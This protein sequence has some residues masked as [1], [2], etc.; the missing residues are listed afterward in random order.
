MTSSLVLENISKGY[1]PRVPLFSNV[2]LSLK[3]GECASVI[4]P[5]A[6]GKSTLLR[7]IAGV[8]APTTGTIQHGSVAYMPQDHGLLPW[9]TVMGNLYLESDIAGTPRRRVREK[10]LG[11][12]TEFGLRQYADYYPSALSGG[13]RQK[14]ALLRTALHERPLLVLDEPFVALDAQARADVR[15]W[16]QV[17][18]QRCA[19][20][21][22]IVTHDI[23]EAIY[24]SDTIYVFG[25]T[26]S[27]IIRTFS[28]PLS[29]PR[30]FDH[31]LS[32]ALRDLEQ[33]LY[34]LIQTAL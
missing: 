27:T 18:L 12:L 5:N 26:P 34:S 24:L 25:G 30:H 7:I 33:Q 2:H 9:R 11:L 21:A 6:S 4:G 19:A 32:P 15:D 23:R 13:T 8:E 31:L 10:I 16:L 3:K 20:S 14:V 29:R 17:L 22:I 1:I 28:V